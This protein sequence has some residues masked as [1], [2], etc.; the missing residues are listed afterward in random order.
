MVGQV[1]LLEFPRTIRL[2][3]T[4]GRSDGNLCELELT[5]KLIYGG[6]EFHRGGGG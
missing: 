5:S 1:P 2:A 6:I 4:Q 3:A